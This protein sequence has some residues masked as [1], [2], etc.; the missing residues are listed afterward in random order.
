[1]S[2]EQDTL[3]NSLLTNLQSTGAG[4]DI[5]RYIG[6][7]E[8]FGNESDTLLYFMGRNLARKFA[9]ESMEDIYD[10]VEK[11]GWGK[12][13][14]VKEK[15]KELVFQLMADSVAQRLQAPLNT[16]FRLEAGFL[17][18]AVQRL[19]GYECECTEDIHRKIHQVQFNIMYTK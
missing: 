13:D 15:K 11:L 1:M 17:A 8:L 5:L 12:L 10:I 18:E 6:L 14:L 3:D 4:Y 19:V 2:K 16:D 9:I 7:P